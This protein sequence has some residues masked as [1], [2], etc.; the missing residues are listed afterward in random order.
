MS[1]WIRRAFLFLAILMAAGA[2]RADLPYEDDP[3]IVKLLTGLGENT[4]LRLPPLKVTGVR[5]KGD[6]TFSKHGPSGRDYGNKMAYAPDR[7]TAMYAGANH[8]APS[9]LND[10]WEYHLGSNTW[11]RLAIGD[12]GDHGR[13]RR[14]SDAIKKGKDAEKNRAFLRKWYADHVVLKDGYL[15]TKVNGGPV[16]PWH[17][18]DALAYDAAAGKLL[19][20][21]LDT[22]KVM[23][24]KVKA[25]AKWTDQDS[26]TLRGQLKPGT[27]LYMFPPAE[28]RWHR[29]LGP[30]PRPYLRGMGGSLVYIPDWKK[31][32]WYCAAQNVSP[33]D[34]A[35]W[36][37]DA[38]ANTWKDLKPN[39]G[40]SIRN[41][42][43]RE[44]VAPT[45]EVQMAY[46]TKDRKIVAVSKHGTWVYDLAKNEWSHAVTDERN[47][48]H[49]AVTIFDYDSVA[50][51]FI[52]IN[53]P[54]G[55]WGTPREVR[56]FRLQ[57]G[58]WETL[59][60][61]GPGIDKRPYR[62]QTGYYDPTHNVF[63]VYS[64]DPRVW[65]FRHRRRGMKESPK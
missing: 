14:A 10:C 2:A 7:Q 48:A 50:D 5:I 39:G 27:G 17:T 32:V 61:T 54:E 26:E 52:L 57:T 55:H 62:R 15:Q 42:V 4:S 31:T 9:R 6:R 44:K 28:G 41:L 49:D 40:K 64:S 21:V 24:G 65:V 63:V 43:H 45:G 34:F 60:V 25:Y 8:G 29:Q 11:V 35:M 51:A 12:G 13:P 59:T 56:S 23:A 16:S 20:A 18:W 37:Y 38:V 19:W 58:K 36:T 1:R 3:A 33:N 30:D 47:Q 46:S 53:S 22:D